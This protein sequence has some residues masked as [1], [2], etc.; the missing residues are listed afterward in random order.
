MFG[1]SFTTCS[2]CFS[3]QA[4]PAPYPDTFL[5]MMIADICSAYR[6]LKAEANSRI[7]WKRRRHAGRN[8]KSPSKPVDG[9]C[10]ILFCRKTRFRN[11]HTRRAP[12]RPEAEPWTRTSAEQIPRI[13][14]KNLVHVPA[15][16][17]GELQNETLGQRQNVFDL[18]WKS[19]VGAVGVRR[20]RRRAVADRTLALFF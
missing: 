19:V 10:A 3:I 7:L 11:T 6:F 13:F 4:P 18:L 9:I 12:L 17:C 15:A 5:P 14:P 8:E 16:F 20:A 1:N 2:N